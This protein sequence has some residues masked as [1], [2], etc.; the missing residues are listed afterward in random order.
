MSPQFAYTTPATEISQAL[1][2]DVAPVPAKPATYHAK[3]VEEPKGMTKNEDDSCLTC[4]SQGRLCKGTELTLV[5]G[6]KRCA[7]CIKPGTKTS[8]R[9]CYWKAPDRGVNTYEDA[10]RILGKEYGGRTLVQNTRAERARRQQAQPQDNQLIVPED[11]RGDENDVPNVNEANGDNDAGVKANE[12]FGGQ[13]DMNS[14]TG[15]QLWSAAESAHQSLYGIVAEQLGLREGDID[16]KTTL[17]VEYAI[18]VALTGR[19]PDRNRIEALDQTVRQVLSINVE[20]NI[21]D[22]EEIL[23]WK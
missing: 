17:A 21:K 1:N 4:L 6:R 11:D 22:L 7:V 23:E 14:N 20:S 10:Q 18:R 15:S 13:F 16:A 8:G 9:I 5:K 3:A 19:G 2:S 12:D